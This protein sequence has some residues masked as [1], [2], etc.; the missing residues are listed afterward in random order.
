MDKKVGLIKFGTYEH[1]KAF[2]EKGEMY[3][4]TFRFFKDLEAN[5]DGRADKNEYSSVHYSGKGLDSCSFKMFPEGHEEEAIEL[6]R[7]NGFKSLTLDFGKDK[8]YSHLYSMSSID[9][10]EVLENDL[11]INPMNFAPA[12]D[13]AVVIYD[14]E[15]FMSR[16]L[17]I[18]KEKY[19]C[20]YQCAH[21]DYVDKNTYSGEMGVFRKF[22][23]FSYQNEY[24]IAVNFNTDKP[25]KIYLDSLE[26]IAS[27]PMNKRGFYN[28]DVKYENKDNNGKV[29]N[30]SI[31]SNKSVLNEL[32]PEGSIC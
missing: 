11:L 22:S 15:T 5:G 13:Y 17:D 9:I 2:Y 8:E 25:M 21:I 27:K 28:M 6:S 3:F 4:N 20:N 12:K 24:R 7:E 30:T 26:H 32:E 14:T 19:H 31:I 18:I 16:F 1:M 23:D 29:L 10:I